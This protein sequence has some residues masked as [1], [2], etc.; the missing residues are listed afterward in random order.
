V[1][2]VETTSQPVQPQPVIGAS[3]VEIPVPE[4]PV[5]EAPV[6]EAP[7]IETPVVEAPVVE[8]PVVEAAAATSWQEKLAQLAT[9]A[10]VEPA[11]DDQAT[12]ADPIVEDLD[13]EADDTADSW[14]PLTSPLRPEDVESQP[15]QS[16]NLRLIVNVV[17]LIA[18]VGAGTAAYFLFKGEHWA[19][20]PAAALTALGTFVT[21]ARFTG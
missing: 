19:L 17:M 7:V 11:Y 13:D 10:P 1:A 9:A 6:V 5:A 2:E 14:D 20:R 4:A 3:V 21:A 8:A 16:F 15:E 18:L 12:W